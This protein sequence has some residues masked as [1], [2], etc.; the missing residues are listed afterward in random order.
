MPDNGEVFLFERQK[1]DSKKIYSKRAAILEP[2]F[3]QTKSNRNFKGFMLKGL[4]NGSGE[5]NIMAV[6]HNTAKLI[7][8]KVMLTN[9]VFGNLKYISM[10]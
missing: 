4:Y 6:A 8:L 10:I 2:V 3:S 7:K 1:E 5:F 9:Q